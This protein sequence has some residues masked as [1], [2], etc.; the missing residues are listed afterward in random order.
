MDCVGDLDGASIDSMRGDPLYGVWHSTLVKAIRAATKDKSVGALA[1]AQQQLVTIN[2]M[3]NLGKSQA[4]AAPPVVDF[5]SNKKLQDF[6]LSQL[7]GDMIPPKAMLTFLRDKLKAFPTT[8][9]YLDL[10]AYGRAHWDK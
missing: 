4:P 8:I 3:L 1:A 2:G 7:G 5:Q 6:D 9:F 10:P